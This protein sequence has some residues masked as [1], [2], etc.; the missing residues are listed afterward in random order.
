MV[1]LQKYKKIFI[2]ESGKYLKELDNFLIRVEHNPDDT[3]L[4]KEIHGKIH[5]IKGMAKAL[6]MNNI[7][8][9]SHAMEDW[10]SLFQRETGK[11]E[12]GVIQLFFDGSKLLKFLVGRN[13]EISD[14]ENRRWY[15][16]LVSSFRGHPSDLLKN[17]KYL[18][19]GL[20]DDTSEKI[21]HIRVKYSL[22]EELLGYAQE[23]LFL[24]K[25]LPPLSRESTALK[26]WIDHYTSM[27][28]G[29]YFRLAQLRLMSVGDFSE[30][31][32]VTIRNLARD[33]NKQV[34]FRIVGGDLQAD[35]AL[36]DRLREPFIHLIRNSIA[37]G[38]ETAEERQSAGKTPMGLI[39][40]EAGKVGE[41]L[42]L[43]I[44][45]D[46]RGISREAITRY[47]QNN[48]SMTDEQ[49]AGLSDTEFFGTI[50]DTDFSSAAE[51]SDI[52]GR[53]IGMNV[54][55]QA[56]EYLSGTITI[57]SQPDR[58]TEFLIRLPV[59]LSVVYTITFKIGHYMLSIPTANVES[60]D[61]MG[62]I[63]SFKK[64][65]LYDLGG[66]LGVRKDK[67]YSHIM[68]VMYPESKNSLTSGQNQIKFAVDTIIGNKAVM[69]LPVGELLAKTR[70]FGGVGIM[71]NGDITMLL[72]PGSR[73]F[74]SFTDGETL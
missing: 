3:A 51:T 14:P 22:I 16:D 31:F 4:W 63:G 33:H 41:N 72:D 56:I 70:A 11:V 55:V 61:Q 20:K 42:C 34:D 6:S 71:E 53:G 49:I 47:L 74:D 60:I 37:H 64:N 7:T 36:L 30:L 5:S 69:V 67:E 28:K 46:G 9:L 21:D 50:F 35:I 68:N 52:A 65:E 26:S 18:K 44:R 10:C 62:S 54:V 24:E 39:Q 58:G 45:D 8:Q 57:A 23:T 48:R 73:L 43:K 40:L 29:L 15:A 59:S 66:R 38:I 17:A 2:A 12:P 13:D 1:D 25:T 19:A 32:A 27:L